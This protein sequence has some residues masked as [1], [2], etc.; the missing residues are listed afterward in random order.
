MVAPSGAFE[1]RLN[2]NCCGGASGSLALTVNESRAPSSTT[3]SPMIPSAGG[4]LLAVRKL[5]ARGV[6][7]SMK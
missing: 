6:G 3:W 5:L 1:S 7:W 2:D 4:E